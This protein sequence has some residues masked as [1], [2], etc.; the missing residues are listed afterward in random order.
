MHDIRSSLAVVIIRFVKGYPGFFRASWK[1]L[2][3]IGLSTEAVSGYQC[4]P[5]CVSRVHATATTRYDLPS[6]LA[7]FRR[8][9]DVLQRRMQKLIDN[10]C[11]RCWQ[12]VPAPIGDVITTVRADVVLTL[13]GLWSCSCTL[14]HETRFRLLETR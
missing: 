8:L 11:R 12:S 7:E 4:D 9:A 6:E 2:S 14:L 5:S 10:S 1:N 3:P 13:I